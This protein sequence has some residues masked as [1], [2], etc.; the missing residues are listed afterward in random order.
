MLATLCQRRA[1]PPGNKGLTFEL[2]SAG[3]YVPR[4]VLMD[5]VRPRGRQYW[6]KGLMIGIQQ[7][8]EQRQRKTA[9]VAVRRMRSPLM[10]TVTLPRWPPAS[11]AYR[12]YNKQG[13]RK[14]TGTEQPDD[15]NFDQGSMM[16]GQHWTGRAGIQGQQSS[17]RNSSS[18]SSTGTS[19]I[20]CQGCKGSSFLTA[21]Q[22]A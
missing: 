19:S 14:G 17:S 3:R 5:L 9:E 21:Q 22:V 15:W 11:L 8:A 12:P 20:S 4:A 13:H 2:T 6:Y 7:P 16:A 10:R 18:S 1:R